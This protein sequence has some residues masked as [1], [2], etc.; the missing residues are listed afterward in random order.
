MTRCRCNNCPEC[1]PPGRV[2][3]DEGPDPD[4]EYDRK[5]DD[6]YGLND[7]LVDITRSLDPRD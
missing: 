5:M 6:L 3:I 2:L 7:A 4:E 1:L